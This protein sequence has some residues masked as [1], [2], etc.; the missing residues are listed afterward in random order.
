MV[1]SDIFFF[2]VNPVSL[3]LGKGGLSLSFFEVMKHS[4]YPS[5][6]WIYQCYNLLHRNYMGYLICDLLADVDPMPTTKG[7]EPT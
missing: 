1:D 5:E 2:F 4:F 7:K 6:D 3:F